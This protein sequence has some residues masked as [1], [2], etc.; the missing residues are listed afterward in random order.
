MS[1]QQEDLK[2]P[3]KQQK[4]QS[5]DNFLRF[6]MASSYRNSLH[7]VTTSIYH[8]TWRC[9]K[10]VAGYLCF[11][12]NLLWE[13]NNIKCSNDIIHLMVCQ[14]NR[15]SVYDFLL[16]FTTTLHVFMLPIFGSL[17]SQHF[18]AFS[19]GLL[20]FECFNLCCSSNKIK[21]N[22]VPQ[23]QINIGTV[24]NCSKTSMVDLILLD[25]IIEFYSYQKFF[26]FV[27][28]PMCDLSSICFLSHTLGLTNNTHPPKAAF[29]CYLR[30][31]CWCWTSMGREAKRSEW[32]SIWLWMLVVLVGFT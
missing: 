10:F 30:C 21:L 27:W 3:N 1:K 29:K 7:F 17:H 5:R 2:A 4:S 26:S 22:F 6:F 25:S 9:K 8:S 11:N 20:H 14:N 12:E 31:V 15:L 32:E 24:I 19:F 16:S 28:F 13:L 23:P 18:I